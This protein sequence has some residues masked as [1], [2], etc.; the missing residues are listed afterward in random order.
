MPQSVCQWTHLHSLSLCYGTGDLVDI[1]RFKQFQ[2]S[3]RG[4]WTAR[5][6]RIPI[7]PLWYAAAG[8]GS[9]FE[10]KKVPMC[11]F[12]QSSKPTWNFLW[13]HWL[14]DSVGLAALASCVTS[15]I[16]ALCVGPNVCARIT[17][18][19]HSHAIPARTYL[20][21]LAYHAK[22]GDKI[23]YLWPKPTVPSGL[24]WKQRDTDNLFFM[25]WNARS[26]RAWAEQHH[27]QRCL[28]R[29]R[30]SSACNQAHLSLD[31]W[32]KFVAPCGISCFDS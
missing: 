23:W 5:C 24:H 2:G 29:C 12:L 4:Q 13:K 27:R 17:C 26:R 8:L 18:Y 6:C 31:T 21:G 28:S 1:T 3:R 16:L 19:P 7:F 20:L 10:A 9:S 30:G 14:P 22:P 25:V 11:R 15:H 32:K